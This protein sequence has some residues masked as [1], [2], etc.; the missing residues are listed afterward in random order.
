VPLKDLRFR[1]TEC[2]SSRTDAVVMA[3]DA[4]RVQ[5]KYQRFVR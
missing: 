5:P 2:G 3:R 4:L 1:Y